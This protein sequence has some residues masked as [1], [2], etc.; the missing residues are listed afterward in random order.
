M[1]GC[2]AERRFVR[3]GLA[4]ALLL[5]L[6]SSHGAAQTGAPTQLFPAPSGAAGPAPAPAPG[7]APPPS[8]APGA[9]APDQGLGAP[10]PGGIEAAPLP[11]IANDALGPLEGPAGLGPELWRG[12]SRSLAETLIPQIPAIESPAGRALARRLLLTSAQPPEGS[13]EAD[14]IHLRAERL[15]AM[16]YA[17]DAA[18]LLALAPASKM[19]AGAAGELADALL[20]AGQIDRACALAGEHA[21]FGAG[22]AGQR[23]QIFCALHAGD[24]DR[25]YLLFDIMRE[26][27]PEDPVFTSALAIADGATDRSLPQDTRP[28]PLLLA[29]LADGKAH[30]PDGWLRAPE[31]AYLPR[32][33]ELPGAGEARI[34]AAERA[35][36]L[37]LIDPTTLGAA[38][39]ALQIPA[40]ELQSAAAAKPDTL[41]RRA[42]IYRAAQQMTDQALRARLAHQALSLL[43]SDPLLIATARLHAPF[44]RT[45][46]A[47][48]DL[49]GYAP[50][51]A[52]ALLLAGDVESARR[53]V[54]L[55][56]ANAADPAIAATLPGLALLAALNGEN[57]P[58]WNRAAR[59]FVEQPAPTPEG[60]RLAV[61]ARLLPTDASGAV[62]QA[63]PPAG[64]FFDPG[65]GL[66]LRNAAAARRTGETVLFALIAL[67]DRGAAQSDPG[68]LGEAL[69]ALRQIGRE[70]DARALAIEAAIANGA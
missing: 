35:A 47:T 9:A 39:Q 70:A 24:R 48:S 15:L 55:A 8:P 28:D 59:R 46:P 7:A 58:A 69:T 5:A 34:A 11:D 3:F 60:A 40:K 16:G 19:D 61:I 1:S 33:V 17:G 14:F 36:R 43:P 51:F 45:L 37:G 6:C 2:R 10:A 68:A 25:A 4:L 44:L 31:T 56:R 22:P 32:L 30:A 52:R 54:A 38:Y 29:M 13:G 42:T 23:L 63:A 27:G 64:G 67:G 50:A 65:L 26:Q 18:G 62:P 41:R 57:E 12:T 21:G 66:A 20:L 49:A 53:W